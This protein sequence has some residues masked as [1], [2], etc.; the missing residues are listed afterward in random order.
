[1]ISKYVREAREEM[2]KG[3]SLD[4]FIEL[5]YHIMS[6][7]CPH[8]TFS[9]EQASLDFFDVAHNHIMGLSPLPKGT[10]ERPLSEYDKNYIAWIKQ[11]QTEK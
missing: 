7:A 5:R 8:G 11:A 6:K 9:V 1:M 4:R 10:P 3:A 2:Q